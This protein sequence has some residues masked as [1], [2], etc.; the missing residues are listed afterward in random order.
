MGI[1]LSPEKLQLY[2][3]IDKILWNDWDPISMKVHKGPRDEYESY[4]P[5]IFSLKIKGGKYRNY[6]V[7]YF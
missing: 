5:A 2:K 7:T 3:A 6:S 4:V 1:K